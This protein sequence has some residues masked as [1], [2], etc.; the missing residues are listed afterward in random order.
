MRAAL[1]AGNWKLNGT[2]A[3]AA[4]LS[5]QLL[6]LLTEG[7]ATSAMPPAGAGLP[8][9]VHESAGRYGLAGTREAV[10]VVICPPFTALAAVGQ[11][12]EGSRVALGAQDVFWEDQGAFTGEVSAPMLKELGC[13]YVIVGHSERR[14]HFGETDEAVRR[15]LLAAVRQGLSPIVCVGETL[16]Q[17]EASQTLEVLRRQ[18]EGAYD[19][20][21]E[22][23]CERAVVAYE[24]VW[25]IGTG[26][27]A[28]PQQAQEAHAEIRRWFLQRCG[29]DIAER[30]RIQYGGSVT[31]D[32]AASL[33]AQPDVDGAL[34]G[35]ASLK[36]EAFAAI[37][38]AAMAK[39][40]GRVGA[41]K[42]A[43]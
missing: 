5:R 43:R 19:G 42:P 25:A 35:G 38:K 39:P 20:C 12:L 23:E 22:Q 9:G 7:G 27:N 30:L 28:T 32:N 36:A 17:R 4:A 13:R 1:I 31:P 14:A 10:E 6:A 2:A 8:A 26:R 11:L 37:V 24:P 40:A 16:A 41:A 33:L 21:Q 29:P 18:L 15:K 34:V 3:E